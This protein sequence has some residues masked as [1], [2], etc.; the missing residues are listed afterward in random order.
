MLAWP[1]IGGV[2]EVMNMRGVIDRDPRMS[3]IVQAGLA[4]G[5]PVCGHARGL[6]G[7]DLNAFMAAGVSSDHELTSAD[8]LLAK[9]RAGLTHRTARLAR[10]PAAGIRRGARRRSATCRRP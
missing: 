3:A 2:A 4:S 9:L 10:L 6:A 8:D 7:A 1:E 5:K